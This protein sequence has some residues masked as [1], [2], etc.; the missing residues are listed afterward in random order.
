MDGAI[1]AEAIL[2][3]PRLRFG[4]HHVER[5]AEHRQVPAAEDPETGEFAKI[6]G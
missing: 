2:Q 3:L 1:V 6:A 5:G 4:S